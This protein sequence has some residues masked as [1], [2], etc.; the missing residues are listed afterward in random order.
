MADSANRRVFPHTAQQNPAD[1]IR[2]RDVD[3]RLSRLDAMGSGFSSVIDQF[4]V[5]AGAP[6]QG[7]Q[8]SFRLM[9]SV[10]LDSIIVLR[11]FSLDPGSAD[12][13][14]I[15][16]A[17]GLRNGCLLTHS[18]QDPRLSS[19]I[20]YYWLKLIPLNKALPVGWLGPSQAA[21]VGGGGGGSVPGAPAN[22]VWAG[23][24]SGAAAAPTFRPLVPN[25]IP[26]G[27]TIISGNYTVTG[28]DNGMLLV[29]NVSGSLTI[30]LP[31]PP[32][33]SSFDVSVENPTPGS[34]SISPNGLLI[35]GS[36]GNVTVVKG[37]G[38]FIATDGTNYYTQRGMASGGTVTSVGL[39]APP[40]FTVSG[41]PVTSAGTLTFTKAN[42]NINTVWAAPSSGAAGPPT[43]RA[44]VA[45]D[46]PAVVLRVLMIV[47]SG[48]YV[49]SAGTRAI[50]VECIGGGGSGGGAPAASSNLSCGGGGGSGAYCAV[51]L[52]SVKA[53]YN[54]AIGAGAAG[55]SG[56]AGNAGGDTTFDSP[57]V[58]TAKGGGA[59]QVLAAGT[60]A[61]TCYGGPGGGI[62]GGNLGDLTNNGNDGGPGLRLSGTA[63]WGGSGGP[64]VWGG[65]R[66][67]NQ[68]S[69]APAAGL[70]AGA[71]GTG[72][73]TTATV[74][75][76]GAGANGIVRVWEFA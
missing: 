7:V 60:A 72:A 23:P 43:F 69:G 5:V 12:Q 66:I 33:L 41:S 55:V 40:E 50:Y 25:D 63:G 75:A 47:A 29:T 36:A 32:P 8:L 52:T 9:A 45:A 51:W 68:V 17:G 15:F 3:D 70:A 39:A 30:T 76:G 35:D 22:T 34:V 74:F 58:C 4:Q 31:N 27:V 11:N 19:L 37:Q 48:S 10:G 49:P 61:A 14:K 6:G 44:L 38:L 20:A 64:S 16:A 57:S 59:G 18:D 13:V 2:Q 62:S 24:P 28:A 56:A 26:S 53:S 1:A 67:G 73:L 46:L 71:G 21:A 65:A 54:L 42:E